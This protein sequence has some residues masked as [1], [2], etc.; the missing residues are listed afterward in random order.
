MPSTGT[1]RIRHRRT[2]NNESTDSYYEGG[3]GRPYMIK[4]IDVS[5]FDINGNPTTVEVRPGY[6]MQKIAKYE[7]LM[8]DMRDYIANIK[9]REGKAFLLIAAMGDQNWGSNKNADF[10]PTEALSHE[11]HDYGYLTFEDNGHWY[12]QHNNKDPEKSYG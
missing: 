2:R 6:G 9:P 4:Y 8:Q 7:T 10:W 1:K 11:G 3:G 5:P 12:H